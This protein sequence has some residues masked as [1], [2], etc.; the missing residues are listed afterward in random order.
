MGMNGM[1][2]AWRVDNAWQSER[3]K[4]KMCVDSLVRRGVRV[5]GEVEQ[6]I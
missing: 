6:A 3:E 2:D 5:S 4:T 1:T